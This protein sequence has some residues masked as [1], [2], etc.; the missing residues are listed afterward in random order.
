MREFWVRM[1]SLICIVSL[2]LG[3]NSVLQVRAK[4]EEI[5]RL[6][7]ETQSKKEEDGS[8]TSGENGG[9]YRGEAE[10]FGGAIIVDVTV[11]NGKISDIELVSAEG[12]DDSYLD[13]AKAVIPKIREEQ[14]TDVDVVSGATFS[15]TGIIGAV[16]NAL[17]KMVEE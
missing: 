11:E 9:V 5:A 2:I 3:Y 17:E 4:D 14:S 15:S 16:Q 6:Q 12:E 10:G 13:M 8:S 1:V 7:A